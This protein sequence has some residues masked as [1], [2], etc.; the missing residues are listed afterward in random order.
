MYKAR[1][2]LVQ[3]VLTWC[4]K[5]SSTSKYTPKNLTAG[6]LDKLSILARG[7]QR[8]GSLKPGLLSFAKI[9]IS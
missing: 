2:T 1:D 9:R 7:V 4:L 3:M 6:V 8:A 5:F